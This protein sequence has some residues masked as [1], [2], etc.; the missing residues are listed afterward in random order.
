[1][2]NMN[3]NTSVMKTHFPALRFKM[4]KDMSINKKVLRALGNPDH[5][6]FWWNESERVLLIGRALEKTSLSFWISDRYYNTRT[7]YKIK[8]HVFLRA[9]MKLAGWK[10]DMTY[11]V[12][13]EFISELDMVAFKLDDAVKMDVELAHG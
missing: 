6:L 10:C 5:I 8:Q 13:G 4:G 11:G 3:K 2:H 9:I 12:I 7:C 1:M